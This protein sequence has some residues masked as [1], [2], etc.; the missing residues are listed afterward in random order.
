M[1]SPKGLILY[2]PFRHSC[3]FP[4]C[5][6]YRYGSN[7]LHY[8]QDRWERKTQEKTISNKGSKQI[9]QVFYTI[10]TSSLQNRPN[11]MRLIKS[12][13]TIT[14]LKRLSLIVTDILNDEISQR[15]LNDFFYWIFTRVKRVNQLKLTIHVDKSYEKIPFKQLFLLSSLEKLNITFAN[16]VPISSLSSFIQAIWKSFPCLHSQAFDLG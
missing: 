9:S 8:S 10:E 4:I 14:T 13:S 6:K 16:F 7:K 15:L 3:A 5:T 12:L 11:I 2:R 1:S